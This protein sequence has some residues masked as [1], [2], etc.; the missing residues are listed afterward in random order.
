MTVNRRLI[1]AFLP[2]VSRP[3]NEDILIIGAIVNRYLKKD[4]HSA[5][6]NS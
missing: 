3:S 4:R 5:M 6:S 1:G 2:I